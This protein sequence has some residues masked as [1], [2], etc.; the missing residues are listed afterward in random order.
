MKTLEILA[1]NCRLG[2]LGRIQ[3][4]SSR[5]FTL[6]ELMVV[7]AVLAVLAATALPF[8]SLL[9]GKAKTSACIG[10]VRNLEKSVTAYFV[11]RGTLPGAWADLTEVAPS[12]LRDPWGNTIVYNNNVT[13]PGDALKDS[14]AE[15]LNTD[16]DIYSKGP[17]GTSAIDWDAS[18]AD[19]ITRSGDGGY[20]GV[21]PQ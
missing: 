14:M 21:R 8:Y 5:G 9:V 6:V 3:G 16:F 17:N 18:G 12:A 7:V 4:A 13:N 11:D 2:V 15:A 1:V 19:D 10:D 20:V